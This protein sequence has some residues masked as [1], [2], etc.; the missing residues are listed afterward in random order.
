M[1]QSSALG[2]SHG[3]LAGHQLPEKDVFSLGEG[4]GFFNELIL[5]PASAQRQVFSRSQLTR[6]F[7]V[8][9]GG[10]LREETVQARSPAAR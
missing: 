10:V 5:A 8:S 6:R 1:L 2:V 7:A 3:D 9:L 4:A